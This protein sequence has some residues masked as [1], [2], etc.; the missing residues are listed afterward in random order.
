MPD[1][2]AFQRERDWDAV[3]T[4]CRALALE[5]RDAL[6]A[7]FGTEPIAPPELLAQMASVRLPPDCDGAELERRLWAERVEIPV[8]RPAKDLLRISVAGYTT[9]EDVERLLD[10][11]PDVLRTSRT[12]R[13]G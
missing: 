3:R 4:R 13:A 9:R 5:A 8:M 6:C 2:I 12:P 1:A 10:V 7:I 11:L